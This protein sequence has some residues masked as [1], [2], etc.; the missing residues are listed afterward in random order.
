MRYYYDIARFIGKQARKIWVPKTTPI[1]R[2]ADLSPYLSDD[3]LMGNIPQKNMVTSY[4]PDKRLLRRDWRQVEVIMP[5]VP[6]LTR[7]AKPFP[8]LPE[9]QLKRYKN[10]IRLKHKTPKTTV[11]ALK[12]E[13]RKRYREHKLGGN[14]FARHYTNILGLINRTYGRYEDIVDLGVAYKLSDGNLL[15]FAENV[16]AMELVDRAIGTKQQML[17][18]HIYS[19]QWYKSPFGIGTTKRIIDKV[20]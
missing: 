2:G 8:I 19:Q 13:H 11:L 10:N 5:T 3:I 12:E 1:R 20:F 16:L 4:L 17:K 18:K 15:D 14:K 7:D 6:L 9:V